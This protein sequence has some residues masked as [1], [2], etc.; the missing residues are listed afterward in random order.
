MTLA[1]SF[2]LKRIVILDV[3]V[4]A[5]LYTVRI[6]AGSAAVTLWPPPWLFASS[7]LL[8]LSLA[9]VKRY[10]ELVT[11]RKVDGETA[12]ARSYQANARGILASLGSASGYVAVLVLALFISSEN[13]LIPFPRQELIWLLCPALLYWV[14]HVWLIAHRGAMHDDP[15][16]FVLQDR[17][18]H[19]IFV[20]M[21]ATFMVRV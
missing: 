17:V 10:A 14:S 4:L 18:S 7:A 21:A 16:V 2:Y 8:F 20:Y 3:M 12:K 6:M 9:L 5:G 19:I 11:M 1:Y 15:L 13:T